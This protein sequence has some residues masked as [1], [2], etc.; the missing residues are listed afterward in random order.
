MF[1]NSRWSYRIFAN[2]GSP[3]NSVEIVYDFLNLNF[4]VCRRSRNLCEIGDNA[5]QSAGRSQCML[6]ACPERDKEHWSYYEIFW[7]T[8]TEEKVD[9]LVAL[10]RTRPL[11]RSIRSIGVV[12]DPNNSPG[13]RPSAVGRRWRVRKSRRRSGPTSRRISSMKV[14]CLV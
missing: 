11:P 9:A 4:V 8:W 10:P 7:Q 2:L 14:I 6:Q 1:V 5:R 12:H 13:W 3:W